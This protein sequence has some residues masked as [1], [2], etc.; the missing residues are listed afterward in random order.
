[1]SSRTLKVTT[2]PMRGEDVAGWER[3]MNKV[4]QGW[5][6]K[7]YRHPESGAYGVGDRSLAASIAYGYGIAAGALEG[8]I[9]PELRIK[10]RN[11][12]FSSAELERYHVRADWRRRLVKRLE[13][14]SEPGV[15]RLVAKVTQ[16]SWGWHPPVHDGIDL[17]CPANALLYAPARCRVIDVRSSGWWG[18]GAQPSG[19]HP[20]SDG[21]G[22]I[23]VELLETVG[24]LKKGLHLGFGHAEGARVRVGQVVQAG[25]VLGHAGFANA[26]H[27]HFM[28]NDGRF[29]LQ[30]RGSQDPRP[31]T[32]YCQ[33]NG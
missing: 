1:M 8:G 32:D 23:Q 9:T 2:P 15:H 20:V 12:R 21:D 18:K 33:K 4:L 10:I 5:G 6:A 22:I 11:K 19:G 3:T 16:D 29:G 31:I 27:V 26:W 13:Q 24:P 14:A 30:G 7:T 17:I 25:D 28:V